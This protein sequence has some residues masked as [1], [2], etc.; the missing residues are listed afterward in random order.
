MKKKNS[1]LPIIIVIAVIV[2]IISAFGS[3]GNHKDTTKS[4]DKNITIVAETTFTETAV[5]TQSPE[6]PEPEVTTQ[7]ATETAAPEP[8]TS[9]QISSSGVFDISEA[10]T[11]A[12]FPYVSVNNNIPYFTDAEKT[13]TSPFETFSPLDNLGRC[14]VAYAN[15]CKE[16]MPT[17]KRGKIGSVKPSGWQSVKYDNVDGKYLYN[18]C[19]LIGFQLSGENAN[20]KNL[21]TGT[22]YMNTEGM[23]PFENMVHDFVIETGYHVLYRVTPVF[24]GNNLVASGVLMEAYSVEDSGNG[25]MFCIYAYNAQP[26]ISINY[27]NGDSSLGS[28]TVATQATNPQ[29]QPQTQTPAQIVD[30]EQTEAQTQAQAQ[31]SANT[32]ETYILNVN[33]K[34]FHK[35]GCGSISQIKESNKAVSNESRDSLIS[36]GYTP[37]KNCNP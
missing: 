9:Q 13:N 36:Q 10:G 11:Y 3:S 30:P 21:I 34:K 37:C 5:A 23:L 1:T 19:H 33:S 22:R 15:I 31:A 12:G 8:V 18:R 4:S 32:G 35:Q 16:L 14:G 26:G 24:E 17:E 29:T 25:I 20:E 2:C 7:P 28:Q 6:T 27:A